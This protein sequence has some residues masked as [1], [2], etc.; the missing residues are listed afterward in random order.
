MLATLLLNNT[1]QQH[2][3]RTFIMSTS[4]TESLKGHLVDALIDIKSQVLPRGAEFCEGADPKPTKGKAKSKLSYEVFVFLCYRTR[5]F[6][7]SSIS[8]IFY[9]QNGH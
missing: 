4:H 9:L 6:K 5:P 8:V 2:D 1:Q 7:S 3:S